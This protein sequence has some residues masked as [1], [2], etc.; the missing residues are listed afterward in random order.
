MAKAVNPKRMAQRNSYF[1]RGASMSAYW[2]I[3]QAA[4]AWGVS[5]GYARRIASRIQGAERVISADGGYVE[6]RI[7]ANT[8]IP[9]ADN[10]RRATRAAL[11]KGK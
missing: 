11:Q 10:R 6:W 7:P 1:K 5:L 4:E 9:T 3:T 2:T 8:P